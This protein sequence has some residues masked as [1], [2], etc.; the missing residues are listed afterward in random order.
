MKRTDIILYDM[1]VEDYGFRHSEFENL[2]EDDKSALID[3]VINTMIIELKTKM[4]TSDTQVIDKTRGEVRR[5]PKIDIIINSLDNIPAMLHSLTL[6]TSVVKEFEEFIDVT[7]KCIH[8][9][10]NEV[11]IFRNAYKSKKILLVIRYQTLIN[12]FISSFTTLS[13]FAAELQTNKGFSNKID[14]API[15]GHINNMKKFNDDIDNGNWKV[16]IKDT[17]ML[18]ESFIEI[19][20]DILAES[21][22][23]NLLVGAGL[24]ALS[25][26]LSIGRMS[27]DARGILYKL[28][29][30]VMLVLSLREVVYATYNSR[31]KFS[32][33]MK[34]AIDYAEIQSGQLGLDSNTV[35]KRLAILKKF[36]NN[37]LLDQEEAYKF[38]KRDIDNENKNIVKKEIDIMSS[39]IS[40][41]DDQESDNFGFDFTM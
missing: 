9:V 3:G 5:L 13:A 19:D 37:F 34:K 22:S 32:E 15:L 21:S 7:T 35:N 11:G 16:M 1:F 30:V 27:I 23:M 2:T 17:E 25:T 26:K 4:K 12:S 6:P 8:N 18:R 36:T 24:Q 28:T 38:S 29:G 40:E 10:Y 20:P 31:S 33:T 41:I 14:F 39:R